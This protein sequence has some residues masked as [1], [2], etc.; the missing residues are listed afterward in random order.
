MTATDKRG[1]VENADRR[2]LLTATMLG[3]GAFAFGIE[4][5]NA[6]SPALGSSDPASIHQETQFNASRSHIYEILLSSKEFAAMTGSAADISAEAGGAF[7][8]FGGIIIGRNIELVPAQRIVQAWKPEYWPPGVYSL[9]KF[10][11]VAAG[12]MTRIILDQTGF[13]NGTYK[14]LDE[15]WP[16]RYWTPLTKYLSVNP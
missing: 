11:F 15:G 4:R 3:F 10:E 13:P 5:A 8:M 7:S 14:G 1:A 16:K 9:V 2:N 6:D 12:A